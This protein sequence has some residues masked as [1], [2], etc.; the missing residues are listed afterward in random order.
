M[1]L[2]TIYSMD[3]G[4]ILYLGTN[5]YL[6]PKSCVELYKNFEIIREELVGLNI[7]SQSI[8]LL[9]EK[10]EEKDT[11]ESIQKYKDEISI[12]LVKILIKVFFLYHYCKKLITMLFIE[13]TCIFF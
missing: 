10:D 3:N 8:R 13:N 5:E 6:M 11:H 1:R 9:E 2:F 7:K 4:N 12:E